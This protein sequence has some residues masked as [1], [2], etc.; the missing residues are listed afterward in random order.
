MDFGKLF[1]SLMLHWFGVI[2]ERK[3]QESAPCEE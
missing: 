3:R 1:L 2:N